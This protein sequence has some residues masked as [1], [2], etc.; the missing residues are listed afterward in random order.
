M[1][2]LARPAAACPACRTSQCRH[3]R[4]PFDA[5]FRVVA[6]RPDLSDGAKLLHATLVSARRMGQAWTQAQIGER[7]GASRQKVWRLLSELVEVGL[8]E[9]RRVGLGRPN[10]YLLV[11]IPDEDL[12]GRASGRPTAGHQEDRPRNTKP[13]AYYY[14]K[15]QGK[16]S[17]FSTT[18]RYAALPSGG[19][20]ESRHGAYVPKLT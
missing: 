13:D 1:S 5:L 17:G 11:G 7:I 8:L 6:E 4:E 10:E 9:I 19:Y 2:I 3:S 20:L 14:P 15:E 12:D 18:E 16:K